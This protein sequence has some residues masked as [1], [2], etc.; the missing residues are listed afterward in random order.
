MIKI[1]C[2]E[3]QEAKYKNIEKLL[4]DYTIKLVWKKSCQTGLIELL[5]NKYDYLLLD[6]SMPICEDESGKENFNNYA[7]MTVL[8]EIK[9]KRYNI[10]VI[11]ITGFSDF[12]KGQKIITLDE[13]EKD[14]LDRYK[15]YYIGHIKYDT[16]SIE[17][18]N[19]LIE[20][21]KLF[22]Y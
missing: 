14:I 12:E 18:Q 1:L 16:S 10:K 11:V 19:K 8:R 7:G 20:M 22:K 3:D 21:L 2:M 15:K 5:Y 4:N 9:R 13:L 17:W 6:M